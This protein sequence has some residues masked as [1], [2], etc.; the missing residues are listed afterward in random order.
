M[1]CYP[2]AN[3]RDVF[4]NALT[5]YRQQA[6]NSGRGVAGML[7]EHTLPH[8]MPRYAPELPLF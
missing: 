4:G 6:S 2:L 1:L 8:V 5:V 3:S 7:V